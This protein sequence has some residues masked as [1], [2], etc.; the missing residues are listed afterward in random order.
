[1]KFRP[2][3][4]DYAIVAIDSDRQNVSHFPQL[5]IK[6]NGPVN[7]KDVSLKDI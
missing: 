1:M 7:H 6:W 2:K 4:V 3:N 5:I